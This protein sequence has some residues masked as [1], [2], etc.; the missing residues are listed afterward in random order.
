[1]QDV[2]EP[3][4]IAKFKN[5]TGFYMDDKTIHSCNSEYVG[6]FKK[7]GRDTKLNIIISKKLC[8]LDIAPKTNFFLFPQ[9]HPGLLSGRKLH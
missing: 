9:R 8:I 2:A 5:E 7:S 6:F 1:M 3:K 4:T